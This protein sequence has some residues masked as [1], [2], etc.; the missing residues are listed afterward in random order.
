L[1]RIKNDTSRFVYRYWVKPKGEVPQEL[2]ETARR[3]QQFWNVLVQLREDAGFNADTLPEAKEVI[4]KYFWNLLT[5]K[6][7]EFKQWRSR[8]KDASALNWES[9]D[10]VFDRFVTAC[11]QAAK[12]RRGWPKFHHRLERIAIP[13][14]FSGGGLEVRSLFGTR[15]WRFR[16]EPVCEWA[17]QGKTRR[18]TNARLTSGTFGLSKEVQIRFTTVL[19]RPFPTNALVKGVTWLGELHSVKGWQWAIAV[20]L[21]TKRQVKDRQELPAAAIDLGWRVMGDYIRIGM[22]ADSD[23]NIAELRLPLEASTYHSRRHGIV[24]G[25]R[26]LLTLDRKISLLVDDVKA[27]VYAHFAKLDKPLPEEIKAIAGGLAKARQGGLVRLL[28]ALQERQLCAASQSA[29]EAW[30]VENDRMRSVRC[31]L[32]DRLIR[33]RQWLY[34]NLCAFVA[35]RYGTITIE[36]D[37]K[38]KQMIGGNRSPEKYALEAARRYRHWAAVAELK[39]D[40]EQ[41]AIKYGGQLFKQESAWTTRTCHLCGEQVEGSAALELSCPQGH[42]WDQDVNAAMNLLRRLTK[43]G[44]PSKDRQRRPLRLDVPTIL[45]ETISSEKWSL[46]DTA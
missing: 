2:W 13:H 33:R 20:S 15:A 21:E 11:Q 19:H 32:Q 24:S 40:I 44:D 12:G 27:K 14:R 42:R 25:W 39:G 34:R 8:V 46:N 43:G 29:L 23:G 16:L 3:M 4:F 38:I 17:Y 6:D 7:A 31:A 30:L 22:L 35:R 41:A 10:A 28:R 1:R 9:R 45:R 18:H 26:D 5:G 36:G 37:L